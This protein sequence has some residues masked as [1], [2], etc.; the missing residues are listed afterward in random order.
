MTRQKKE[1][2]SQNLHPEAVT[3]RSAGI[4][5]HIT[6]LPSA[7]GI[8]DIGPDAKVFA[9]FLHRCHQRYWQ[10]LPINPTCAKEG[11]SPYSSI[12]SM[13]GNPLLI[14]PELLADAG[15]LET[16]ELEDMRIPES[17]IADFEKAK[18]IRD[19]LFDIAYNNFRKGPQQLHKSF[20]AFCKQ[21]AYWLNDFALFAQLRECH[22]GKPWN[23]WPAEYKFRD[24]KALHHFAKQHEQAID[25][26]KWLQYIFT[27]QWN[28]LKRY[29]NDM[30]IQLFG[31][32]PFYVS[33]DSAD[34]WSHPGIFNLDSNDNMLTVAGVPPDY[35]NANGQR[36][37]TPVFRWDVLQRQGYH[38]WMR[39][40]GKNLELFDLLRLDHFRAFAD[41]W[42]VPAQ[43]ETA[44][45]GRWKPGPG[46]SFFNTAK[47]KMGRLP[48]VAE[49]L[50][51]INDAVHQLRDEF[52]LPGMKVL[53]FAFAG[54]VGESDYIPHN[55][56][57]NFIVYTG[58]HDNNTT[59]GWI[60][61]DATEKERS[62]LERYMG[63]SFP[64]EEAHLVLG[65]MAY[66]SVARTVILPMQDVLGLD[67]SARMNTPS[68]QQGSWLWRL[69]RS[70][71][72][73]APEDRLRQWA[74]LYNRVN[75]PTN[76]TAAPT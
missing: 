57:P 7:F 65:R 45:N 41:Y 53:Q 69:T 18:K 32:L 48:F 39:R 27:V 13:A 60:R 30:G 17:S 44:V 76:K 51:M 31:D 75:N 58:T 24:K 47:R 26:V 5:L 70:Q 61:K 62:N 19:H 74:E 34:V 64:N 2:R 35:F 29:C 66:A 73:N 22:G 68:S 16:R 3:G 52:G 46:S 10:V 36:W 15:L 21:E 6:S 25:K 12:S 37:G 11:Y 42:E 20:Q 49:D 4:L 8:G 1:R 50:G 28:S 40:I 23:E 38:W 63:F 71:L 43:E 59:C 33:Y 55:Y 14:S 9:Q 54:N 56:T 67:E 72:D